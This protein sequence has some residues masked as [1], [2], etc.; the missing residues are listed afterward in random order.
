MYQKTQLTFEE[1]IGEIIGI[2][3]YGALFQA[4]RWF[5]A[6]YRLWTRDSRYENI[7]PYAT[8]APWSKDKDF[9]KIYR[10]IRHNTLVDKYRCFELWSLLEQTKHLEGSIIEI[11]VW[12]GGTGALIAQQAW[13]CGINDPVY[14]CD[15]FKGVVKAS[16]ND[17]MYRGGEHADTSRA[18][19]ENLLGK[20]GLTNAKILEGIFPDDTGHL[21]AGDQFRFCHIDVDVYQSAKDIVDWIW[22]KM[23][24]GG[25]IVY[26][27]YGFLGCD[28]VTK[29]VE[30]QLSYSDRLVFHNLNGHAVV[31]K[32]K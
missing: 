12:K 4:Y 21:V 23:V 24:I 6:L 27:D 1:R 8:Y 17:S 13:L 15:T 20:L 11:G 19:V 29:L 25:I 2:T 7:Y 18:I 3:I 28:G 9:L 16:K 5:C 14:L 31:V 32:M 30:E 10:A 22:E 26:D